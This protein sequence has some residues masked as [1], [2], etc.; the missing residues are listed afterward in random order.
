[1][2]S[3]SQKHK[4]INKLREMKRT[5][6]LLGIG[7]AMASADGVWGQ[8]I[9]EVTITN[10]SFE[11]PV[12]GGGNFE[13]SIPGWTLGDGTQGGVF[14][15]GSSYFN[16]GLPDGQQVAWMNTG[17]SISQLLGESLEPNRTYAL[18]VAV[19]VRKD[20]LSTTNYAV[21]L[22]AG[23][24]VLGMAN[25]ALSQGG[26]VT[27]TVNYAV[28]PADVSIGQ[29]LGIRLVKTA[30][31]PGEQLNFDKVTLIKTVTLTPALVLTNAS[32]EEPSQAPGD[33]GY[34]I[35]GWLLSAGAQGGVFNPG[36]VYFSENLPDGQQ[37]AWLNTAGTISQQVGAVLEPNFMYTLA[38]AV[39]VRDDMLTTTN[40]AVQLVAGGQVLAA[41]NPALVAGRFVPAT[42]RYI[43]RVG[44]PLSGQPLE[45][46]LTKAATVVG[47][48]LNFDKVVLARS[49]LLLTEAVVTN[50]SFELPILSPGEYA[51][52]VPGWERSPGSDAGVQ[53]LGTPYFSEGAPEGNQVGYVN[54]NGWISQALPM[55]LE[56]NAL[57]TLSAWVG[58]R[59]DMGA[60]D[61]YAVQLL[62][63][64]QVVGSANPAPLKGRF[65]NALVE[66]SAQAGDPLLGQPLEVRLTKGATVSGEQICF[67]KVTVQIARAAAAPEITRQPV[68]AEIV[69]GGS[70]ALEVTAVGVPAPAY[71][72]QFNG[73]NLA[74]ANSDT[75]S[76]T[77]VSLEQAGEYRVL[78]S[79]E[80]GSV[81][82]DAAWVQVGFPPTV[83]VQP[84]NQV[85]QVG[86]SVTFTASATGA[87]PLTFRWSKDGTLIDGASTAVLSLTNLQLTAQG[88]Y[89]VTV[90]NAFGSVT[91]DGVNLTVEA[92][93]TT[94]VTPPQGLVAW[95]PLDAD[96]SDIQGGQDGTVHGSPGFVAGE[97]S[98]ALALGQA[99]DYV[100]I[101]HSAVTDVGQ[102][103]GFTAEMWINPNTVE[104]QQPLLE[105]NDSQGNIGTL[106]WVAVQLAGG[107]E[108]SLF[109]A[110]VDTAGGVHSVSSA[111][112]VVSTNTFQHVAV[113]Y[114][115]ATGICRLFH[116]GQAVKE[117]NIGSFTP[118]TSYD[119]FL[120][121]RP[122]GS[123]AGNGFYGL[124]DE[125]A[126]YNRAL[127][128]AELTEIYRAGALGKCKPEPCDPPPAELTAWWSLDG[129]GMSLTGT[130]NTAA[131]VGNPQ[132]VPGRVDAAVKLGQPGD[133]L[134]VPANPS[135]DLGGYAGM[136]MELWINPETVEFQQPLL[137]WNNGMGSIGALFWIAVQ[138]EGGGPGSLFA[139]MI[140]TH[141]V[142]HAISS[143][144]GLL[145]TNEFQH[146]AV[147][148]ATNG[149]CRL[150]LNGEVVKEQNLGVW[151]PQTTYDLYFGLRPSGTAAGN[152]F[153]GLMD[154]VALYT[155]PLEPAEIR[156]HYL[157]GAPNRCKPPAVTLVMAST[158]QTLTTVAGRTIGLQAQAV[159]TA[160][161][162][163]Q[164]L[165]NGAVIPDATRETYILSE[166]KL[167]DAGIYS[168]Q[169][170]NPSG[171]S[172]SQGLILSVS[173]SEITVDLY[174]GLMVEGETGK[175]YEIQYTTN[176]AQTNQWIGLTNLTL[177]AHKQFW[178]DPQPARLEK[179]F[180]RAVPVTTTP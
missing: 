34:P 179:R 152:R 178:L 109:A 70:A 143:S 17:G 126:L 132:F 22:L 78:I 164:W 21:E 25:P 180:Y 69:A 37:V 61:N 167:S 145:K 47:E 77:N 169:V 76:L 32:F 48:Q 125:V 157:I 24:Q 58:E 54:R 89:T 57:Y 113:T 36:G 79:N 118:Q 129:H 115:K 18:S 98:Q 107:G 63:G 151:R 137:E 43:P 133:Y 149:V 100:S 59:L 168:V 12:A 139:S 31:V 156:S 92:V 23:S 101:P 42:L 119:L 103:E 124:M 64:G 97:V 52:Q 39:G 160:P 45:V 161:L 134:R 123:A 174:P 130:N 80:Y 142:S 67:D 2:V 102:A 90:S 4:H 82:S 84:T 7:L 141:G 30:T 106:F 175:T 176:L 44:D 55:M 96:A 62:A 86:Q 105:W 154:E 14:N 155:K 171:T 93:P 85:G 136:T 83:S 49:P 29:P 3:V 148:Y 68:S 146:V 127:Q 27:A 117:Q 147:T 173:P 40:Y 16:E 116:N 95:W 170:S 10:A 114:D 131:V 112:G 150:L 11:L 1:M 104:F 91:S 65:V 33:F 26:F 121:L 53:H 20:M 87:E 110:V 51:V 74:G 99:G 138:L 41:A 158:N 35:A 28:K 166:V 108:G 165:K 5:T 162:A 60:T 94:C 50:G 144:P 128:P 172:I 140:D 72:W 122:S 73:T 8:A 177:I 56:P 6:L 13:Y 159:G 120:G 163:F 9:S 153:Y 71:Q 46:R 66:Y 75:L 81:T 88:T 111:P 19:G 15:P 38:V 135:V